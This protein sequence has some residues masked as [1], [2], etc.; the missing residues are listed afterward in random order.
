MVEFFQHIVNGLSL[1]STYALIALGYTM[2]FGVLQLI[3]FAHGDVFMLGAFIGMYTAYALALHTS[4]SLAALMITLL[5]A[6]AGCAIIGFLIERFAYRPLRNAPRINVLITA[7][8]VSLFLEFSGQII[9]GA[10]PKFFPQV[11]QPQGDWMIA[12]VRLNPLQVINFTISVTLML[13]LQFVVFKTRLGRALR[14]VSF[15]HELASLMGIPTN[16]IISLT[17]VLGSILAGAAGVLVALSYPK[18]DPLMGIMPGIKAFAAAVLGGI[19][20]ITGAVIGS[21]ILGLA[22]QLIV[23]YGAPTY[24]DALAFVIL[25]LILLVKPAGI[26][27]VHRAE[28][29]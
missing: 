11:Y 28:K 27:G 25:I 12:G 9:F 5:A 18:I 14:A 1:G 15:N 3:N 26:M 7:V 13:V 21:F 2:V 6:M 19:G 29:V 4:P 24:R 10:D 8:G 20:N 17:F 22:E 16:R 23:A